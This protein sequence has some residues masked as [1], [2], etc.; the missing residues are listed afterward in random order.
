MW[1][2]LTALW[3]RLI[4]AGTEMFNTSLE[5]SSISQCEEVKIRAN[6]HVSNDPL[7]L[8]PALL[9]SDWKRNEHD[10][11]LSFR[12]ERTNSVL[13][14][15][16]RIM[17]KLWIISYKAE[18]TAR[19]NMEAKRQRWEQ[20]EKEIQLTLKKKKKDLA[21]RG[22]THSSEVSLITKYINI[23]LLPYR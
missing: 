23:L 14:I 9:Q 20:R 1:I 21:W 3:M 13:F 8:Q 4:V 7:A 16:F 10:F 22:R 18:E 11:C 6:R 5:K 19:R 2:L 12:T 15:A 17:A